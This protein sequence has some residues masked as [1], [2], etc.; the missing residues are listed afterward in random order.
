MDFLQSAAAE[1]MPAGPRAAVAVVAGGPAYAQL[2]GRVQFTQRPNGVSV[3]ADIRG[4]PSTPTGFF[5]FHL[6]EGPCGAPGN[7]PAAYFPQSGMHYNPQGQPHPQHA[8]DFPP[9]LRAAGGAAYLC[10]LTSRFT[11]AQ[12]IGRSVI[13]HLGPDDFKTQPSG[14]PGPKIACGTVQAQ[15]TF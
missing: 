11:L 7:D 13:I 2:R 5:A 1:R 3:E 9:L 12:I 6:H 15:S 4:L 8:G 14:N 10:F